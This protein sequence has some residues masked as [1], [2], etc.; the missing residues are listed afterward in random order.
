M[1][2]SHESYCLDPRKS[3]LSGARE[4]AGSRVETGV[5]LHSYIE[6]ASAVVPALTI[7]GRVLA[8]NALHCKQCSFL[9]V[10]LYE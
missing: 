5:A 7:S 8:R 9:I 1:I 3:T 6:G 2:G 10:M 4:G